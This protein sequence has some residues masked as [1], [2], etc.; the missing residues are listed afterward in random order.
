VREV[1][2]VGAP[3]LGYSL[4]P[5]G[6]ALF[7]RAY[8][9]TLTTLLDTVREQRGADGIVE[10]F[11]AQWERVA[12]G[13]KE[14]LSAL[15]LAERTQLLAELL[16]S[17]GYMAESGAAPNGDDALIREHNCVLRAV[18]ERFPEVCVAEERFLAE[19]L[20]AVVERRKHIASG[21]SCCEYC[22]KERETGSGKREAGDGKR[23]AGTASGVTA[24]TTLSRLN[25][26]E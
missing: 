15:P 5:A 18:A 7:P 10:L 2:G 11:R 8:E 19:F 22:V 23:E 3:T 17:H 21:A 20:G 25:A 1:R 12:G 9:S 4:T 16:T 26:H 6:E 13:A 14:E 24:I